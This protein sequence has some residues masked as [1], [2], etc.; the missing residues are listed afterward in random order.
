MT[1]RYGLEIRAPSQAEAAGL[2]EL[3]AAAGC[4]V[5]PRELAVRIEAIRNGAGTALVAVEWGP[6]SGIV[7]LHWYPTLLANRPIAQITMLLVGPDS[8]RRG[9]GRLLIKAAAQSAR[10]AGCGALELSMASAEPSLLAFCRATGFTEAGARF[11]RSLR[12][13]G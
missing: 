11:E 7:A 1:S 4:S 10:T 5:E 3:F 13:Q 12:K 6:P 9:I 8:R 2:A